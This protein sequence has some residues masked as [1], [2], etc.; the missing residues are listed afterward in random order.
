ML[1]FLSG[2]DKN[3]KFMNTV[4]QICHLAFKQTC[5]HMKLLKV[6][7]SA[8]HKSAGVIFYTCAL[9]LHWD[10][11]PLAKMHSGW[12]EYVND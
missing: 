3:K 10:T 6:I 4:K 5:F 7:T 2:A 8:P 1:N 12:D 9:Q 11:G